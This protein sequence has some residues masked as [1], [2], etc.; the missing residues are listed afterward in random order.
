M[1]INN[2]LRYN[3]QLSYKHNSKNFNNNIYNELNNYL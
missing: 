1:K 2:V 3:S